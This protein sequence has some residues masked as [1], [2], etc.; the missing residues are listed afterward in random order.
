MDQDGASKDQEQIEVPACVLCGT[1]VG[2]YKF[3]H[4]AKDKDLHLCVDCMPNVT[5]SL[6]REQLD[7][8]SVEQLKRHMEVRDELAAKYRDSF[9][10][11]KKF[12]VGK[13]RTVPILEVD[14]EHGWWALPKSPMPLALSISSIQDVEVSLTADDLDE[15]GEMLE[16]LVEG[17]SIKDYLP[18]LRTI[19]N[20]LYKSKHTD[21]APIPEGQFVSYLK[22]VLSLDDRESGLGKVEA[23]LLPFMLSLPSRVNAGYDCAYEVIEYLKQLAS[24]DYKQR[25]K[26]R[27]RLDLT[28]SDRL[29]TFAASG[30]M[31]DDEAELLRYYLERVPPMENMG[32]PGTAYGFVKTVV[33]AVSDS[34]IYGER[35]PKLK[36]LHTADLD[37]FLGAFYRYAPGLSLSDVVYI[38]DDTKIQSGKGGLLFA[39][40]CFAVDDFN[41]GLGESEE[42]VQPI[43]YDDLLFVGAGEEDDQLVLAYRDDRRIVVNGGRYAHFIY[44][45]VNCILL[46]LPER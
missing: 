10:A 5:K 9:V 43:Q 25:K 31:S 33:D 11:T 40:D 30:L 8:M 21:L 17:F 7:H 4:G 1:K 28:R 29:F 42:L 36:T 22:L 19:L 24:D 45:V 15:S 35:E 27:K 38:M 41:Q 44:A 2:A 23:D 3:F 46:L 12:C 26:T 20:M 34:L 16:E 14:E 18:F 37:V 6:T 13:R 32:A 39:Q